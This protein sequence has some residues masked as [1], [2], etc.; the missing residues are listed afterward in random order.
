MGTTMGET[1]GQAAG[2]T[3]GQAALRPTGVVA[4]RRA[5]ALALGLLLVVGWVVWA[6]LTW[7]SQVRYVTSEDLR[8]DLAAGHVTSYVLVTNVRPSRG[9]PPSG[10]ADLYDLPALDPDG[11]VERVPGTGSPALMYFTDHRIGPV[12]VLDPARFS[13]YAE[14]YA[15][16]L[17]DSGI[18]TTRGTGMSAPAPD[19]R[20]Q[21]VGFALGALALG[22]VVLAPRRGTATRFFWFWVIG[23]PGA[24][25]VLAYA[26]CELLRPRRDGAASPPPDGPAQTGFRLRGLHG[27]V[28][29]VVVTSLLVLLV[30]TRGT[31]L[32]GVLF[33]HW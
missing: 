29:G 8:S 14:M 9:W 32:D 16:Q 3:V 17:R 12:R 24:L 18:P 1:V 15:Q 21:V 22:S 28:L 11:T 7:Q 5:L 25:G 13:S 2:D 27:F 26:A 33:P 19:D 20:Y 10:S 6:A 31:H 30:G 4:E 23:I